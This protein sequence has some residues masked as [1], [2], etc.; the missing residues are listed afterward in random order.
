[1]ATPIAPTPTLDRESS[2]KFLNQVSKNLD[3]RSRPVPTPRIDS[4]ISTI[5]KDALREQKRTS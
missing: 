4:T 3:K 1:M 5:M 2:I